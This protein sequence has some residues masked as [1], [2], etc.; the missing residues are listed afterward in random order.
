MSREIKVC[1]LLSR[2]LLGEQDQKR[3]N[4]FMVLVRK[5]SI[6]KQDEQEQ[7]CKWIGSQI[8]GNGNGNY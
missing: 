8:N 3:K 7:L 4:K 1:Y 5:T 2:A 6:I